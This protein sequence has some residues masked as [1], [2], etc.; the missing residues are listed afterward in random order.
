MVSVEKKREETQEG[1]LNVS[2]ILIEL[3][4]GLVIFFLLLAFAGYYFRKPLIEI[5]KKFVDLFGPLGVALGFMIPDSFTVPFP[6]DVF[7]FLG[8][9]GGLGFWEVTAWA[10]GGSL[11]GGSI[12]YWIGRFLGNRRWLRE[13]IKNRGAE[14]YEITRRYGL[15]ALG[16]AALTPI[17]YSIVCWSCGIVKI[18]YKKFFL[19]SL[20]R[21]P[22]VA[23][24]L[25]L[26]QKGFITFT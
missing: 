8:L 14:A 11:V 16:I 6:N 20:L 9:Q 3:F 13:F 22:R 7:T 24:Y 10:S 25:W 12:G 23:F 17:P 15:L 1:Q 4:V 21:I 2:K 19:V 26:I 18:P 5:S